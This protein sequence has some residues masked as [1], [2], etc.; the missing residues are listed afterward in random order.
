MWEMLPGCASSPGVHT[1]RVMQTNRTS[2]LLSMRFESVCV[3][4]CLLLLAACSI[5]QEAKIA[6]REVGNFHEKANSGKY[7]ELYGQS[8][9][10]LKQA[11]SEIDFVQLLEGVHRKL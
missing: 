10:E 4:L 1:Q 7:V 2:G 5:S 9:G 11:T 8:S 6:E 3:V